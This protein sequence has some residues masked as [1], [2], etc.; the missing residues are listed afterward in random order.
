M[1]ALP[2][3]LSNDILTATDLPILVHIAGDDQI[4][5][6][7]FRPCFL[8]V[9]VT[10]STRLRIECTSLPSVETAVVLSHTQ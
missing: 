1:G 2:R 8:S 5:A 4:K 9:A 7:L 10:D 3:S 6:N